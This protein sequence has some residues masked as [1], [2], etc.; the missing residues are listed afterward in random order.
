MRSHLR[1]LGVVSAVL[2]LL[3]LLESGPASGFPNFP[4]IAVGDNAPNC[5]GVCHSSV[6]AE[7]L[8]FVPEA[9]AKTQTAEVKHYQAILTGAG[10]YKDLS[11]A[12]REKLVEDVKLVDANAAVTVAA[13]STAAR[14]Q[15]ITITVTVK[16][17]AGP[18]V[19]VSLVDTNLHFQSRP[20]AADGWLVV[21]TPKVIGPDGAEQTRWVD[22][23]PEGLKKNVSFVVIYGVK[24]D[25]A[26]KTFPEAKVTWTLRAPMD[27][28]RY[29]ISA[30]FFYGTEKASSIG[31]VPQ[32]GGGFQPRGGFR[33]NSGHVR[34]TS[35][36]T[37]TVN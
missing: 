30:A 12:D 27:P 23:R 8:R 3:G 33:G 21:G 24:S 2:L 20:I 5:T 9:F 15:N 4:P 13:P 31:A 18:V 14:G 10:V 7:V 1:L 35:P 19:G 6:G 16:G 32:A 25:L 34:F 29:T 22:N 26:A 17:G 37:V 36:V 28:G 11:Q